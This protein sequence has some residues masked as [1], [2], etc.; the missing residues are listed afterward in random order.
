MAKRRSA[1]I[2]LSSIGISQIGD[3]I[4]LI[5]LNLMVLNMTGSPLAVAALYVLKPLAVLCTNMWAGSLVDRMNKRRVMMVL[6]LCRG[7]VIVSLPFA[8]SL[9]LIYVIVFV[10]N[11]GSSMFEPAAT[12]YLTKML[13]PGKRQRFNALRSLIESGGFLLG[14]AIAGLLLMLGSPAFA[15]YVNACS[16]LV[17]G[18]I[19]WLLPDIEKYGLSLK[20]EEKL[21]WC[22]LKQDWR[23]VIAFSRQHLY[24]MTIYYLFSGIIVLTAAIDSLEAAFAKEVL[25]L[26]DRDYGFLV[27]IA[28][29]GIMAGAITLSLFANKVNNSLLMGAGAL[30]V[31]GGYVIYAFSESF[32]MAALGFFGLSFSLAFANTGFYTFYQNNIPVEIMGRVG[33]LYA[34]VEACLIIVLTIM[35]GIAA[36]LMPIQLVVIG[37]SAIMLLTATTL[38]IALQQP[39]KAACKP[40]A[41]T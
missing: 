12:T 26:T 22:M 36:Q 21:T 27:S 18:A 30:C 6:D 40:S 39:T 14:P 17:S 19:T 24:V 2:L 11:M 13:P 31:A 41:S 15:I 16:F 8:P 37:G 38:L 3:W 23:V 33:S 28:G 32:I 29:A 25:T 4:Y 10:T 20:A 7:I 1:L 35:F 34:M 5:A 9:W